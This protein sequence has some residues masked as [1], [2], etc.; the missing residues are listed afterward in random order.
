MVKY[1]GICRCAEEYST[2][3]D[4][5][6]QPDRIEL[7]KR[8]AV[9]QDKVKIIMGLHPHAGWRS[10]MTDQD[11]LVFSRDITGKTVYE[12]GQI[13][14]EA[15][16]TPFGHKLV[17]R[18]A[19]FGRGGVL[20][21]RIRYRKKQIEI[22]LEKDGPTW[23]ERTDQILHYIALEHSDTFQY[24]LEVRD[25]SGGEPSW[26]NDPDAEE[27]EEIEEFEDSLHVS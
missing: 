4:R 12:R 27:L 26:D 19:A 24:V 21:D 22:L 1:L 5:S 17:H 7:Q 11:V 23:D 8:V 16:M 25:M 13:R 3:A 20:A 9:S 6:T 18:L 10:F 14:H 15:L 2:R